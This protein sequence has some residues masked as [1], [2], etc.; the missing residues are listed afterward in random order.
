M[1]S[2]I[3]WI[4]LH[5]L[6]STA[7]I[8]LINLNWEVSIVLPSWWFSCPLVQDFMLN[9]FWT[10][11][12]CFFTLQ[13]VLVNFHSA[14][15]F[16]TVL[17]REGRPLL[18]STLLV[19]WEH[20]SRRIVLGAQLLKSFS[21]IYFRWFRLMLNTTV[22]RLL[23]F[24][25]WIWCQWNFWEEKMYINGSWFLI[26]DSTVQVKKFRLFIAASFCLQTTSY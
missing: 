15:P 19:Y 4:I 7:K 17:K 12:A 9:V 20:N 16:F 11:K 3:E 23:V 18:F 2:W 10:P 24:K 8:A 5:W 13:K 22:L 6:G 25:S 1:R 26:P 14:F 21:T